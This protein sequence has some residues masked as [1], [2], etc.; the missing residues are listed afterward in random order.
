M[1]KAFPKSQFFGFDYHDKFIEAA[2][3]TAN[4]KELPIASHSR[5]PKPRNFRAK[6]MISWLCSIA[7][8]IWRSCRS[9]HPRP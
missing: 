3:D 7:C 6:T 2:R 4:V 9:R 8:T 5:W 1:A